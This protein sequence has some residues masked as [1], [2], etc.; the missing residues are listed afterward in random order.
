MIS[1]KN[2]VFFLVLDSF[3]CQIMG[4]YSSSGSVHGYLAKTKNPKDFENV[5]KD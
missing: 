1:E 2:L 3:Y 4:L 5:R